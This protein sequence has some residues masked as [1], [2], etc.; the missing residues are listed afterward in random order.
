MAGVL[1]TS[2]TD[3]KTHNVV[4]SPHST[5]V[6]ATGISIHTHTHTHTHT[7]HLHLRTH[8]AMNTSGARLII[9]GTMIQSISTA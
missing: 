8:E 9:V 1:H 3:N 5:L 6:V 4:Y 2:L 7:L